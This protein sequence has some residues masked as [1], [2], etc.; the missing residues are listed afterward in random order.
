MAARTLVQALEG[1]SF[2]CDR[3][4]LIE[5]ARRN[6][7]ATRA[8]AALE[9]IPERQYRDMGE[10][11]IAL[12]GRQRSVEEPGS[13]A[14]GRGGDATEAEAAVPVLLEW[15]LQGWRQAVL[16]WDV[17]THCMRSVAETLPHWIR[18]GQRLWFPWGK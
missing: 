18:L 9:E 3:A 11:F 2:P 15:W 14:E 7:L 16:P 4:R 10:V 8:L 17:A 5:Y 1:V 13:A 6:N 12:P